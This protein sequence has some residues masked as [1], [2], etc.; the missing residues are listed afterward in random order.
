MLFITLGT[1]QI[2]SLLVYDHQQRLDLLVII[3]Q[4]RLDLLVYDHQ[5]ILDLEVLKSLPR[6][7]RSAEPKPPAPTRFGLVNARSLVN[8]AFILRDFCN[9]RGL[10]F[11]CVTETWIGCGECSPLIELL[12]AGCFYFNSP[13]SLGRG[14]GMATFYKNHFDCRQ[15]AVS[16]SFSSFEANVFEVGHSNPVLCVVIYRPP[17]YNKDFLNDFADLLAE[18]MPKYDCVLLLTFMCA[19]LIN[20]W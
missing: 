10:D 13:Q 20:S 2:E 7:P 9:S 5:A 3:H 16:T 18:I 1:N 11:L 8:K 4:Q 12:P 17:K 14:G 19:G 6:A 15:R